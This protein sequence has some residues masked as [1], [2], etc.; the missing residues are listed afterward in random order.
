MSQA[1]YYDFIFI[2][3]TKIFQNSRGLMYKDKRGFHPKT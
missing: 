2:I 1:A 3:I